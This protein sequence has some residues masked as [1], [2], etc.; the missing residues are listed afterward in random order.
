MKKE[1]IE[2]TPI[3]ALKY[4]EQMGKNRGLNLALVDKIAEE[5]TSGE[6]DVNDVNIVLDEYGNFRYG[7]HILNAIIKLDMSVEVS[8][9]TLDSNDNHMKGYYN[10][11]SKYE[12]LYRTLR[13]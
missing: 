4:L 7:Q 8:V 12:K 2:I 6:F 11:D 13:K 1:I 9:I 3:D 5:M 10:R